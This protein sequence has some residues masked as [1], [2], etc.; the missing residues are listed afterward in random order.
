MKEDFTTEDLEAELERSELAVL[1][2]K[3]EL[4]ASIA[5]LYYGLLKL[6]AQL[7]VSETTAASWKENVRIMKAM[8]EAGMTNEEMKEMCTKLFPMLKRWKK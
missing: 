1:S 7:K 6:D 5:E 3:T 8:K 2:I 4:I